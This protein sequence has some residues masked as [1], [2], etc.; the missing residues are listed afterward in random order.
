MID[1]YLQDQ[2]AL[3]VAGAMTAV[4]REEFELLLEF[5]AELRAF[6]DGL[7]ETGALLTLAGPQGQAATPP[8]GMLLPAGAAAALKSR[9]C[10]LIAGRRQQTTGSGLVVSGPD[11]LV[12]WINPAFSS[13]CGYKLEELRGQRL[14]PILQGA[15]TDR[16]TAERMR[17]A[18]RLHQPCRETILNYHKNGTPYWVEIDITPIHGEAGEPLWMIARERELTER[19]A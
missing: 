2:A 17:H 11:G 8:A 4:E 3:Y 16:A 15:A 7:A 18:V 12:Q 6:A 5:H 1:E 13:M 10:G 19:A 14:G 9:I